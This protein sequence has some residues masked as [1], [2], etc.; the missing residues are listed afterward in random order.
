MNQEARQQET[1]LHTNSIIHVSSDVSLSKLNLTWSRL[2]TNG[3]LPYLTSALK[4][5]TKGEYYCSPLDWN[6][7]ISLTVKVSLLII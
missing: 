6:C 4:N 2:S 3:S 1:P 7:M 5:F